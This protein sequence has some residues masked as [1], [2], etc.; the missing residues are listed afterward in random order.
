VPDEVITGLEQRADLTSLLL[1]VDAFDRSVRG[2]PGRLTIT[3][4]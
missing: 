2:Y 4:R 3:I 1:E